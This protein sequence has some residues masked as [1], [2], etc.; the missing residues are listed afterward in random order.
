MDRRSL[1]LKKTKLKK[2]KKSKKS[3]SKSPSRISHKKHPENNLYK[4]D[5][6]FFHKINKDPPL[7]QV[8]VDQEDYIHLMNDDLDEV[9]KLEVTYKILKQ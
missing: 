8:D 6:K 9:S 5:P 7:F 1:S 3:S 4:F 2:R